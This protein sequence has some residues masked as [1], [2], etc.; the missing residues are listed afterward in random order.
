MH[1]TDPTFRVRKV[2]GGQD[3]LY[4]THMGISMQMFLDL[5]V[6]PVI[7]D[8]STYEDENRLMIFKVDELTACLARAQEKAEEM[9]LDALWL[10]GCERRG[11]TMGEVV[12]NKGPYRSDVPDRPYEADE[13]LIFHF[14]TLAELHEFIMYARIALEEG[15][16][17]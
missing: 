14:Q 6:E 10:K 16:E 8:P 1:G 5:Y 3:L 11:M 13:D 15:G 9:L 4:T 7:G 2:D 12:V 17:V